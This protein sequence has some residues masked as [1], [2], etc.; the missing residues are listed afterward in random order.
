MTGALSTPCSGLRGS[1]TGSPLGVTS[2]LPQRPD[3]ARVRRA[4]D[5]R[6]VGIVLLALFVLA[7]A[8]GVLGTRTA[9]VS[10]SGAGYRLDVDF[11]RISRSGHAVRLA[12]DVHRDGGFPPDAPVR[13]QW[14]ASYF[15]L[16]DENGS[17]PQ[18]DAETASGDRL[19]DE[20]LPPAGD[21]LAVSFDTRVQPSR[22]IGARGEV[23]VVDDAG[24]VL[25]TARWRTWL[26]P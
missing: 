23:S 8:T 21:D 18:P 24:R 26:A 25:V 17:S 13:L 3:D 22:Q 7:G 16:F 4:R 9:T 5:L 11:P 2:T 6:R 10:A 12:V 14:R 20:Y 19:V 1:R 15:D